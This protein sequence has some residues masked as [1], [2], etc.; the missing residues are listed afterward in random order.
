M[1]INI[2]TYRNRIGNFYTSKQN[3]YLPKKSR[4]QSYK[5]STRTAHK[6]RRLVYC[7]A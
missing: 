7:Q 5:S 2:E 3:S 1:D 6:F 4:K